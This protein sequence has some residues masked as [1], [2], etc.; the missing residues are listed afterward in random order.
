MSVASYEGGGRH[1]RLGI[2]MTN[3]EYFAIAFNV[4]PVPN[5][6]GPS[7]AVVAGMT[8]AVIAETTRLHREATQ[9]YRKY[10][11]VDQAIK[12]LTIESFDDAYMNA[13]SDEILG[14]ANC[15]SLQFLTHLLTY[16]AMIAP[17]ELT[18]N[19]E[20]LNTPY[21]PNQPIET[22][23]QQI[24]DA[25]AFAVAGG[26]PYGAAMIVN[27]AYTVFN[28]GLFLDGCRAW[29]SRAIAIKTWAQF[30]LDFVTAHH[31]FR[32]TNQ[33]SQQ[34][35]FHSAN[36]MIEQGRDES[37]QDTIDAIAQLATAAA[38]DRG[39]VA[40]LTTTNA[41][42]STQLEAAHAQ[43]AHL[44]NEIATLKNKIKPAWQGQRPVK[45]TNNDSY[46]WSHGYQVAKSHTSATWAESSGARNDAEGQLRL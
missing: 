19:Y 22:L 18:Q 45:T 34:S 16:Y 20:R 30:K 7:A 42:L 31:E 33:N 13:L 4:F 29:Q 40:T 43:I 15:T 24:Q 32:L 9:L 2:I 3:E 21:N 17:T 12:K 46:C 37:M 5:N 44:K 6:P 39:T 8:A 25:R 28:T 26:R 35:G 10:H 23:F 36:M 27:V 41:K 14:Y 11:N 1:G 38:L